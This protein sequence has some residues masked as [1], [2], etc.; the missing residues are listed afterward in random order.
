[1]FNPRWWLSNH[2]SAGGGSRT[3]V[4][5]SGKSTPNN[6]KASTVLREELAKTDAEFSAERLR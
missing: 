5:D 1:M 6:V 2:K 4:G 3:S